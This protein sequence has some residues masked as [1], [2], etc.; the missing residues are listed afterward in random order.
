MS[1]LL[2]F[3]RKT[4]E[5]LTERY[6]EGPEAPPRLRDEVL[7]FRAMYPGLTTEDVVMFAC[8]AVDDAYR[9]GFTRGYEWRE[10]GLLEVDNIA[11]RIADESA[12][13]WDMGQ[14]T[15]L[16]TV[17]ETGVDPTDPLSGVPPEARAEFFD[18]LGMYFGTHRVVLLDEDGNPL[19]VPDD[20]NVMP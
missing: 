11:E 10:R 16:R 6:Y 9:Q 7:L 15:P 1:A 18:N 8:A 17:L 19:V 3:F 12:H 20:P 2:R 4:L 13:A 5:K 14:D